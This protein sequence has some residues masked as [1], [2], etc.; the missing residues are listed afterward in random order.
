MEFKCDKLEKQYMLRIP[1]VL[2]TNLKILTPTQRKKMHEDI[3]KLMARAC[4]DS[5]FDYSV[6]TSTE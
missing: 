2:E 6:Y 1:E 3:M 5:G 4:Y